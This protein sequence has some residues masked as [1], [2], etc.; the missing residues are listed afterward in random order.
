M[1]HDP[2]FADLLPAYALGA[3]DGEEVRDLKRH[4]ADGCAE[5]E[6][7]LALWHRDI[8]ALAESA[9]PVAPSELAR[10]RLLTRVAELEAA[11]PPAAGANTAPLRWFAGLAA[12]AAVA[13]LA[14]AIGLQLQKVRGTAEGER[15]GVALAQL[16]KE[17]DGVLAERDRALA[18]Q[19]IA[20]EDRDRIAEQA[21]RA[22]QELRRAEEELALVSHRI[23]AA[24]VELG[25]VQARLELAEG[26]LRQ[27]AQQLAA[28][29][30]RL[31]EAE[32][33]LQRRTQRLAEVE[34]QADRYQSLLARIEPDGYWVRLAGTEPG[35]PL[36][37]DVFVSPRR[38]SAVLV[39]RLPEAAPDRDYQLW[40]I[41]DGPPDDAGVLRPDERGNVVHLV[42]RVRALGAVHTWAVSVEPRGGVPQPTG[43]IVLAGKVG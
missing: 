8:E 25:A 14:W 16:E 18:A 3:L 26:E 30:A 10:A 39:A 41:A 27:Q 4:L 24:D 22:Q 19:R 35:S 28:V 36:S 6:A 34:G 20:A 40:S 33:E 17:R 29:Q 32:A 42:E 7:G 23:D 5:C 37:A 2:R 1:A 11:R 9:A 13:F 38:G 21:R 43:P 12:A 15:L 31:Q